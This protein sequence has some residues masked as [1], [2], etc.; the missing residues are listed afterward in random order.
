MTY[1]RPPSSSVTNAMAYWNPFK[2]AKLRVWDHRNMKSRTRKFWIPAQSFTL[3]DGTP[4]LAVRGGSTQY[5]AWAMDA[6]ATEGVVT[7]FII[8][9][10][11]QTGNAD[12]LTC[13]LI[14]TNLGAGLGN[15]LWRT[16]T[17]VLDSP[18]L[19]GDADVAGATA[20]VTQV[21]P[22]Q[23]ILIGA[24]FLTLGGVGIVP[25]QLFLVKVSRIG[26]DAADT[27]AN[28]AGFV[29]LWLSFVAD[30]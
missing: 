9:E 18:L 20:D 30:M 24:R 11:A 3:S 4:A 17:V 5:A 14:Y 26:G 6:A 23:D 27:L 13:E 1:F 22:A 16:T 29:G 12:P 8:P 7:S 15:I 25:G 2:Q 28:D 21:A 19:S 10:D